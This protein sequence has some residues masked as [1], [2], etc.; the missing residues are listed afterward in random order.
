MTELVSLQF[1]VFLHHVPYPGP[2]SG[3]KQHYDD[4][5]VRS[6]AVVNFRCPGVPDVLGIALEEIQGCFMKK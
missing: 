5:Y 1:M 3:Y 4:L 2:A 6:E